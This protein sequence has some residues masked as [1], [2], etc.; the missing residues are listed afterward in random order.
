MADVTQYSRNFEP[1]PE[2]VRDKF[3][4]YAAG[5]AAGLKERLHNP[6]GVTSTELAWLDCNTTGSRN[7]YDMCQQLIDAYTLQQITER[8]RT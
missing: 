2:E 1:I 7:P 5:F 6:E 4:A 8:L 3:V